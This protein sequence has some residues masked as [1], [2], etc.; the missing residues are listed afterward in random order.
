MKLCITSQG[1]DLSAAVDPRFGRARYFIIYDDE[2]GEFE[3]V[4]NAQNVN[5]AGGA[6]VQAAT[7]IVEKG[8]RWVISGHMGPKAM[9]VLSAGQVQVA[10]GAEGSVQDAIGA[11]GAGELNRADEADVQGR[12]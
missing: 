9:S 2:T 8:C 3:A 6:G 10:V 4:D 11:F 7:A 5:A 1:Q 12:W